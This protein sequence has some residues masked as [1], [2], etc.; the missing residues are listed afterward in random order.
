MTDPGV[1]VDVAGPG[2]VTIRQCDNYD[3]AQRAVDQLADADFPVQHVQI[4]GTDLRMVETVTGRLSYGRAA[5]GGMLSGAW[6]GLLVGFLLALF[7]PD[8]GRFVTLVISG[9][10]LGAVFGIVFGLAA[11]A[12]TGGKR[13][14][15][16]RS[17][18]VA[19]AYAVTCQQDHAA[20][21]RQLLAATPSP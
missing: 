4:V 5:G 9:M 17:Q 6:F 19:G 12:F 1:P 20:Q 8:E 3:D 13:D 10:L 11:Y 7:S 14:F 15:T 16:S 2:Q 21:A 18:V